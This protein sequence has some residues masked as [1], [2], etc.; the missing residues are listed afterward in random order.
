MSLFGNW[1]VQAGKLRRRLEAVGRH[2]ILDENAELR[3]QPEVLRDLSFM[4]LSLQIPEPDLYTLWARYPE[5]RAPD[6]MTKRNA[7]LRFITSAE[8]DPY[9]VRKR[10]G[11]RAQPSA[12][13]RPTSTNSA[14]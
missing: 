6:K 13:R 10:R 3:K 12:L 7:W 4:G 9:R 2:A 1:C 8:A 5:L 14:H 11:K